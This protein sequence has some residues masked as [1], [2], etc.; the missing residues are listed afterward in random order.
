[1]YGTSSSFPTLKFLQIHQQAWTKMVNRPDKRK[2]KGSHNMTTPADGPAP[3]RQATGSSSENP[4]KIPKPEKMFP[5][6]I[7]LVE[8][9]ALVDSD[10]YTLPNSAQ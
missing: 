1:M 7:V 4:S 9:T 5:F 10:T 8:N 2:K 6:T 3:K